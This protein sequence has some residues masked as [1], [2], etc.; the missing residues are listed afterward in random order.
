MRRITILALLISLRTTS[1]FKNLKHANKNSL[2]EKQSNALKSYLTSALNIKKS[3]PNKLESFDMTVEH[4]DHPV[5]GDGDPPGPG[6]A[7]GD[8]AG[9]G[10]GKTRVINIFQIKRSGNVGDGSLNVSITK[11]PG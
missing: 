1:S 10:T 6:S 5:N 3:F 11:E 8:G 7:A 4:G 9:P 2:Q